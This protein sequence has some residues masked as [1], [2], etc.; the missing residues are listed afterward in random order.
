VAVATVPE[1][2]RGYGPIKQRSVAAAKAEEQV[3]MEQFRAGAAPF[4]K[5]AE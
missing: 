1:K 3:L 4:L 2:I 5:A